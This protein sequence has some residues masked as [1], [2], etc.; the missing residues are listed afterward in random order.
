LNASRIKMSLRIGN[1]VNKLRPALILAAAALSLRVLTAATVTAE[2]SADE[3]SVGTPVQLQVRIDGTTNV[4]MPPSIDVAG[5]DARMAG[6]SNSIQV[7]VINGRLTTSSSYAYTIVPMREGT[8]EIPSIEI[9]VDGK[10]QRTAPQKLVV[11]P[12]TGNAGSAGIATAPP[13]GQS[14]RSRARAT[15]DDGKMYF[16]EVLVPKKSI[17]VGEVVPVDVRFYFNE[18]GSFRLTGQE[19]QVS[20]EGF[21]VEKFSPPRQ[22][23]EVVGDTTYHVLSF[24]T[25]ITA[26]KSGELE[27]P[28]ASLPAIAR[29]PSSAA[30]PA[31]NDIFSQMFGGQGLSEEQEIKV[32]STPEGIRV[33]GLPAAGRPDSFSGAVGEFTLAASTDATKAA[34]GDPVTLKTAI[35][36]RG[37]FSGMG[38]P[39]LVDTDGWRVYPPTDKFEKSDTLGLSG[40]K[41]FETPIVAQEPRTHTPVAEF[42][43]FD[44]AKEKYFTL[45]SEPIAVE[46]AA[47]PA[48][49]AATADASAT[50]EPTAPAAPDATGLWIAHATPRSWESVVRQP[51]FWIVNGVAALAYL[52]LLTGALVQRSRR[53]PAAA[54]A[55]QV[56]ERD[57]M[58]AD[59]GRS[60]IAEEDFYPKAHAVLSTQA[61]L[62]GESG[63]FELIDAL[64]S[65]GHDTSELRAVLARADEIKFSGGGVSAKVDAAEQRRV[66]GLLRK[67]C[68]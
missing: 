14:P 63:A 2:L 13:A 35:T 50:P 41:T 23:E 17:Y 48:V 51:A 56:R 49:A 10:K 27:T 43:Y 44:P 62:A 45:R 19:P 65:R 12:G 53:G 66:M 31:M 60:G 55:A 57:R 9:T 18:Q 7:Q 64:E 5:L 3:T 22:T 38:E 42:S 26:V 59:L 30:P 24:K 8:F 47:A 68:R 21:T 39:K 29:V 58:I 20:G 37:N 67:V 54:R 6:R 1:L 46:A 16:G 33:K 32:E 34:A 61:A 11:Q 15:G 52:A 28:K 25:A 36:G 40:T 4:I